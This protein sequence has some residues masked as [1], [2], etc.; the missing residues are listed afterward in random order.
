MTKF[1]CAG[2]FSPTYVT[3]IIT[4]FGYVA[5]NVGEGITGCRLHHQTVIV[6]VCVSVCRR[7]GLGGAE[8]KCRHGGASRQDRTI[9]VN[10]AF[11]IEVIKMIKDSGELVYL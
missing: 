10:E 1:I 3:T 4:S 7:G 6:F 9:A 2:S 5:R 11:H 8:R